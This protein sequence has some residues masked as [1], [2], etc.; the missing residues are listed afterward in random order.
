MHQLLW[1]LVGVATCLAA[2]LLLSSLRK[3]TS[4]LEGL[5]ETPDGDTEA[6]RE[7]TAEERELAVVRTL[8][9]ET[10]RDIESVARSLGD[11]LA[12]MASAI[13]G[14][15]QLLCESMGQPKLVA[16]RSEHLWNG[17]R[18]LHNFSEK[19]LSFA[20]VDHL[21]VDR[22]NIRPFLGGIAQ[23]FEDAGS[24]L[25]IDLATSD[26]LPPAY[27]NER[28]LR[29]AVLFLVETLLHLET[30]ARR[31]SLSAYAK[32]YD[33]QDTRVVLEICA[34]AEETGPSH[35]PSKTQVQL[36]Y[37][38]ARNLLEAQGARLSFDELE[39]LSVT[40]FVSLP[41]AEVLSDDDLPLFRDLPEEDQVL[42]MTHG[43]AAAE[44]AAELLAA[45]AGE[46]P[47]VLPRV[48]ASNHHFGGV[49]VLEDDPELR[50]M[51]A[52]EIRGTGRKLISSVDGAS[53]R[54]LIEATPE[55]FELAIVEHDA[56]IESGSEIARL[57]SERCPGI[58]IVLL[59]T[60]PGVGIRGLAAGARLFEIAKPF[61][62][63]ELREA[64][65][66]LT[67][68]RPTPA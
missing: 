3:R 13:E 55:R 37:I 1:F 35:E 63:M 5:D 64:L 2:T 4:A 30:R 6:R 45:E 58:G 40:C 18:R 59:T 16:R 29:N 8:L 43:A 61:G 65:H 44:H 19:I 20:H 38:A 42:D 33:D 53:A 54:S 27:A 7:S 52:Y 25:Q 34:E 24:A 14:H 47:C 22:V 49:L 26:F 31:L 39:G 68:S 56:R 66:E 28:A 46:Q 15:A 41:A 48:T 60:Q 36:G 17:V 50:E 12:T 32:V 21:S 10:R 62:V 57:L 67:G 9:E 51:I 11:E 23:E